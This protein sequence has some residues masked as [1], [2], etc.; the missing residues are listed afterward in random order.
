MPRTLVRHVSG[1]ACKDISREDKLRGE[2]AVNMGDTV[3]GAED[4]GW[5]KTQMSPR[6]PLLCFLIHLDVSKQ[7]CT[8]TATATTKSHS[9]P[10]L[11]LYSQAKES[12]SL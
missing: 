12:S 3:T 9:T 11:P 5:N 4:M 2:L 7:P 8:P 10:S 1:D 6:S